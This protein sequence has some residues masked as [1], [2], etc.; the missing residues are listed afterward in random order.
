MPEYFRS[1]GSWFV[2]NHWIFASLESLPVCPVPSSLGHAFQGR[3]FLIALSHIAAGPLL[4]LCKEEIQTCKPKMQSEE[5]WEKEIDRK[6]KRIMIQISVYLLREKTIPR[7]DTYNKKK[8]W[9][10]AIRKCT[11]FLKCLVEVTF[12]LGIF[13][14]C[15]FFF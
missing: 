13:F 7:I 1:V 8:G 11:Q 15:L 2:L 14:V 4:L 10:Q 3:R 5:P 12:F 6:N 9:Q